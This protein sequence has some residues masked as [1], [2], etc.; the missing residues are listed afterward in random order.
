MDVLTKPV[1]D[2]TL[3]DP[4]LAAISLDAARRKKVEVAQRNLDSYTTL[5]P[6][7][8]EVLHEAAR[9]RVNKQIAFD[10]GIQEATVKLHRSNA[11]RKMKFLSIG[12]LIRAWESLP[13]AMRE[14]ELVRRAA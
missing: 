6:R 2:R 1:R 10:L 4:V 3:L 11:M 14:I 8:R 9:G 7:E 5:T 12:D 13:S